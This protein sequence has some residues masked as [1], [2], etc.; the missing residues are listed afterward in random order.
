[1]SICSELKQQGYE[2]TFRDKT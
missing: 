2:Q 1:Q